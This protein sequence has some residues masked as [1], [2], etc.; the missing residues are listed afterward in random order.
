MHP[1]RKVQPGADGA[2]G[3]QAFAQ[4]NGAS[5]PN[6]V[7]DATVSGIADANVVRQSAGR[8]CIYG[9]GFTPSVA[10]V[11]LALYPTNLFGAPYEV[12]AA[13]TTASGNS[14]DCPDT[15]SVEQVEVFVDVNGDLGTFVGADVSFF[16]TLY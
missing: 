1:V 6:T 2:P 14:G 5:A 10:Q 4:V 16:I 7:V 12:F 8:Y 15:P 9:L 3:A 13:T 11:T